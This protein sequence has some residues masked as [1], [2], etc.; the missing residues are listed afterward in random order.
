MKPEARLTR[1]REILQLAEQRN[2]TLLSFWLTLG[3]DE[4]GEICQLSNVG[5]MKVKKQKPEALFV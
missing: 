3:P 5:K 2:K 4:I 1:I